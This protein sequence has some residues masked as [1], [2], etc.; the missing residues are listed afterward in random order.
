MTLGEFGLSQLSDRWGRKPVILLGLALF[1]AQFIGLAFSRDY[2]MIAA[3]FL[4][5][6]LGNALFDPALSAAI[7]EISSAEHRARLLG[8][9]STAS[10]LGNILG[11]GLIV[12]FTAWLNARGIFLI[13]VGVVLL[14]ILVTFTSR[15]ARLPAVVA[16]TSTP[17][18]V[19]LRQSNPFNKG[20]NY[21]G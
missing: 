18:T 6:G 8:I 10:S 2:I 1:S 4:V 12:L 5:A 20:E 19:D 7:L 11:P 21:H 17:L 15:L 16:S 9:K 3:A 13:S 14:T